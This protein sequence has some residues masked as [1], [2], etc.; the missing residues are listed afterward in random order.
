LNAA[1]STWR[2]EGF[3]VSFSLLS[4]AEPDST[5]KQRSVFARCGYPF[6]SVARYWM[7]LD[8]HVYAM[9]ISVNVLFGFFPFMLLILSISHYWLGWSG[10][11]RAIYVGLR[12]F[13]P[14]DPGLIEFVERNLRAAV[15]ARAA[16]VTTVSLILLL[17]AANGV[18]MPLEVALNRLWGFTEHRPYWKNQLMAVGFAFVMGAVALTSAIFA[19]GWWRQAERLAG[20]WFRTPDA[21]ILALL[22]IAEIHSVFLVFLLIYWLLPN[23]PVPFGRAAVT[24]AVLAVFYELGQS[25]YSWIW[26]S[27]DLR[28]EYGP[29]FISVTLVLWGFLV[30][31]VALAAGRL[32]AKPAL[33]CLPEDV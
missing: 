26:P 18:F 2:P 25:L 22:K 32:Y 15:E 5:T 21:A 29:F 28:R 20:D 12:A 11:E 14:G 27:L 1:E 33:A 3:E 13:L 19:G 4:T 7:G 16:R 30:A 31:M 9:A 24:A 8:S 6:V 17:F 23:G 10:A